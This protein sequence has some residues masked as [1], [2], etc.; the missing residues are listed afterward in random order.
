MPAVAI[1]LFTIHSKE[2]FS[3]E[4]HDRGIDA[5]VLKAEM[6]HLVRHTRTLRKVA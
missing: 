5:I 1:I 4:A 6:V 2:I 3:K